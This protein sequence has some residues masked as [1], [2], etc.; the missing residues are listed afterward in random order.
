[1]LEKNVM[2]TLLYKQ[3]LEEVVFFLNFI[4]KTL[5]LAHLNIR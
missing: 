4:T 5:F 1:M 2:W 3:S